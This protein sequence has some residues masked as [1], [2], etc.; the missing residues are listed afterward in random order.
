MH[1]RPI[2]DLVD[3]L[4]QMGAAIE[5]LGKPGYP[6]LKIAQGSIT[7]TG[8]IQV[9][10]DVSSQFITAL[11]L[12]LPMI[13]QTQGHAL[14]IIVIGELISKPYVALTIN[15]L[16]RFGIVIERHGWSRFIVSPSARYHSPGEIFVEGDASSASYFL[17]AGMIAGGPVRVN[18]VGRQSM[19]GDLQFIYAL[20]KMGAQIA[21]GDHWLEVKAPL[22]GM[23]Q[24]LDMDCN[25]IP[26]AAMTLAICALFAQGKTTLRNIASWR[27]KETDRIAAMAKELSKLGAQVEEGHDFYR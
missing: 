10:G 1:E 18:G 27:V 13:A 11:L 15:L 6:P 20:E 19:Q 7:V 8:P 2:G 23:L 4:K 26:D 12:T 17:A 21:M 24:A 25:E 3:G 22:D 5:Y 9:R 16:A 14:E